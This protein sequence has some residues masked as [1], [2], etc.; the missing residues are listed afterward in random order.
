MGYRDG[1]ASGGLK[2]YPFEGHV[3]AVGDGQ[4][5]LQDG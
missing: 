3:F 1:D 4:D 2:R 5:G